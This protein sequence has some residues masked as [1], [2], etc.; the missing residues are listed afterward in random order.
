MDKPVI[1][2]G[3]NGI[4]KAA[5]EIFISNEI[6][7]FGFLDD[8]P[9]LHG[10]SILD[11]NILGKT[12]DDG[13]LK[14]IGHKCE[15]FVATDNNAERK[16]LVEMLKSRRK[17]MPVNAIH[18]LARLSPSA[19]F[20]YGNFINESVILGTLARI[21]SFN[22]V[23]SGAIIDIEATIGNFV[24]VG[25]GSVIGQGSVIG[26]E[27]FIGSGVTVVPGI[28]VGKKARLGAGS[29]VIENVSEGVTVFGNPA[30][31]VHV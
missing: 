3:A 2:F 21:G 7:V 11:I 9:S 13:F 25:A 16:S 17:V 5:L 27:V 12:N 24:Q 10:K 20:E 29:V 1:I 31:P 23:H 18:K 6:T 22:L 14:F 19:Y 26:N 4:G 28:T 8:D 30:K 15:S